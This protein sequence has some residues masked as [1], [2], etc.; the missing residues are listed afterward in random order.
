MALVHFCVSQGLPEKIKQPADVQAGLVAMI[1][2]RL[3]A[4][5]SIDHFTAA[6]SI[7]LRGLE[8]AIEPVIEALFADCIDERS[9][10]VRHIK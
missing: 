6:K 1:V 9:R 3:N 5:K 10:I 7:L 2:Q 8:N 4:C